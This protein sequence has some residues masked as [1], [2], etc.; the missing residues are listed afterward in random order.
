[1]AT[2]NIRG[3][4][5]GNDD[6]WIYDWFDMEA[7]CPKD[8][9]DIIQAAEEGEEIEVLI[10]SGGGSVM[11]GQEIYSALAK[12]R[13]VIIRIQSLAGSAAGVVAMAGHSTISPVAMIMIHNVSLSGAS[14]DYHDMQKNAEILKQMNAA[15]ASAYTQKSGRPLDEILKLMDKE[16]WL[17][18]N[19]CLDYGF[20]D[21][22]ETGQQSV[23]Y[24]NS[25][26]GMWLTDEI[27]Q[28]A[29]EQRAE[30]EAREEEKKQLLE[31]LD[32]YGV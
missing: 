29:M 12:S 32:L 28:K 18:A 7:T 11:A 14:G 30:K 21:E 8:V 6:K 25:Y 31:D 2:I 16:T 19:Q 13:N 20:V 17:T 26:S 3:D 10:N 24:T 27:R 1:M 4:I 15:M 9:T 23:V 22:I 5:V